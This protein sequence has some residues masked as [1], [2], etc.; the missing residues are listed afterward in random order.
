MKKYNSQ[1]VGQHVCAGSIVQHMPDKFE[2]I[3]TTLQQE[4]NIPLPDIIK[5]SSHYQRN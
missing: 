3:V 1:P 2:R 5:Y 4:N